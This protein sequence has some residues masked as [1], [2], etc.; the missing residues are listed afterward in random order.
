[1]KLKAKE[2]FDMNEALK[3][4]SEEK[5]SMP[6]AFYIAKNLK[7]VRQEFATIDEAR[8]KLIVDFCEKKEDGTPN[9]REDG[10]VKIDET[11]MI[12]FNE[13]MNKLL[14]SEVEI[15]LEKILLS[16]L[17]QINIPINYVETLLPIIEDDLNKNQYEGVK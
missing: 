16:A 13:E 4:L 12:L 15:E 6:T 5:T 3:T 8:Q 7:A 9:T 11:R 1:M 10:M 17:Q 14:N 2:I